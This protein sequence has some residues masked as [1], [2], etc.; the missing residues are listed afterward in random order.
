MVRNIATTIAGNAFPAFAALASAPILAQSLGVEGRG[1]LAAATAPFALATIAATLGVPESVTYAIAR[2]SGVAARVTRRGLGIVV[3]AGLVS[4]TAAI[5]LAGRLAASD[6]AIEALIVI[7]SLAIVPALCVGV[8]R[9]AASGFHLWE[10]VARE[11]IASSLIKLVGVAAL[12]VVGHLTPLTATL[13][14]VAAA[15]L[16]G[17]MYLP[18]RRVMLAGRPRPEDAA[19]RARLL[20]YGARIWVGSLSGILLARVDQLL[21]TPLSSAYE[22]GL[23]VV[24]VNVSEVPLVINAAVRDVSFAA[25]ASDRASARLGASARISSAASALVGLAVGLTLPWWLPIVFGRDFS[26]AVLVAE[27]MILAVVLG[28]PGSIAGAGLSA[29]GRPGLRSVALVVAC[30]VNVVLL[31]ALV[32][33]TGAVGAALATLA[34][35]LVSSNLNIYFMRRFEGMRMAEFYGVRARDLRAVVAFVEGRVRHAGAR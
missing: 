18:L 30:L 33:A 14:T 10:L 12:A 9:A 25:D 15:V 23:Y 1:A 27:I 34:G 28:T 4:T 35:N 13:V 6:D 29:R 16:S 21:M 5:A 2:T 3:L 8:L 32:P 20:N 11:R 24:A 7:A 17:V 19:G 26:G 31:V 22:L